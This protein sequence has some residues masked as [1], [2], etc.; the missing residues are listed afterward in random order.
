[1]STHGVSLGSRLHEAMVTHADRAALRVDD[2]V[3]TYADVGR[4]VD[5]VAAALSDLGVR[6]GSVVGLSAG[7]SVEFAAVVGA[8]LRLGAPIAMISTAWREA[9]LDHAA[10][11]VEP[12]HLVHDAS[13]AVDLTAHRPDLTVVHTDALTAGGPAPAAT[14]VD[15]DDVAVF[16]F[17]SGTTGLPKAVRHTHRSLSAGMDHWIACLGLTPDDRLQI[18][19]PP[20]HILGLLNL[21]VV[22][23]TGASVRLHDRLTLPTIYSV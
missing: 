19:T 15:P 17:S 8:A 5:R 14:S 4:E 20:F 7:N 9:E 11:L 23:A 2:R 12:T 21:L 1:M 13:G 10:G 18:T 22:L 16:V 3:W 6:R